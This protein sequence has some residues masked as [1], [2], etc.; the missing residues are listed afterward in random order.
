MRGLCQQTYKMPLSCNRLAKSSMAQI[1]DGRVF[2]R[3]CSSYATATGIT[4]TANLPFPTSTPA[5]RVTFALCMHW[6]PCLESV[7]VD[8]TYRAG[9]AIQNADQRILPPRS[10]CLLSPA[11]RNA[12]TPVRSSMGAR[13]QFVIN[14]GEDIHPV[15][16]NVSSPHKIRATLPQTS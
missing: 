2:V 3:I 16:R 15:D 11:D 10:T 1:V 13:I 9:V 14:T 5:P 12:I 6:L 7:V 4:V 8:L